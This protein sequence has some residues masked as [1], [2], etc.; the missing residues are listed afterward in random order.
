VEV[1]MGKDGGRYMN[2]AVTFG[3]AGGLALYLGFLFGRWLDRVL[4]IEPFGMFFGVI[5]GA[6]AALKILL[7]EILG[8]ERGKKRGGKE[9]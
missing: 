7:G 2:L 5:I 1:E 3:I 9:P 4:G 6:G 8:R